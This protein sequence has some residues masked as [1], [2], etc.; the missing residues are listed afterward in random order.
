MK[1]HNLHFD[2]ETAVWVKSSFSTGSANCL[3]VARI[4]AAVAVR[5][6]KRPEAG[7]L[8]FGHPEWSAL[9]AALRTG[10]L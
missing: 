7:H 3:E 4:P 6:S 1:C 5:D 10:E 8:A 9:V 2:A